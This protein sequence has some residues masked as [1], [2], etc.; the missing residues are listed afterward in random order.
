MA[1]AMVRPQGLVRLARAV[2]EGAGEWNNAMS[3]MRRWALNRADL[4]VF[5]VFTLTPAR[6]P[7]SDPISSLT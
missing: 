3:F 1:R 6:P 4:L 2:R 5:A 7:Y